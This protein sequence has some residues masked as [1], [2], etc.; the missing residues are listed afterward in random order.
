[1][2]W[3][4]L[5]DKAAALA[6]K[7]AE[8]TAAD[9]QVFAAEAQVGLAQEVEDTKRML[10]EQRAREDLARKTPQYLKESQKPVSE[11]MSEVKAFD[12]LHHPWAGTPVACV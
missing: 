3:Q 10:E 11:I 8:E 6:A 4:Q 12:E 9:I 2:S 7:G 1:M 5:F